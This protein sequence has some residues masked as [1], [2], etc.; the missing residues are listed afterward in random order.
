MKKQYLSIL[1]ILCLLLSMLAGCKKPNAES[2]ALADPQQVVSSSAE[3]PTDDPITDVLSETPLAVQDL[4]AEVAY[5]TGFV[6]RPPDEEFIRGQMDFSVELFRQIAQK[7]RCKNTLIAPF[8]VS[9]ALAMTANGAEGQTLEEMQK[10]LGG[11]AI[12][13][14]NAYYLNWRVGLQGGEKTKLHIADSIWIRDLQGFEAKDAFLAAN[15][16]YYDA[17]VFKAPFNQIGQKAINEWVKEKTDGMIPQLIEELRPETMMILINAL[18]FDAQWSDPYSEHQVRDGIFHSID[19]KEQK[20]Q[21]MGSTEYSY[22]EGE[23]AIGFTRNYLGGRYAFGALLPTETSLEE[24]VATLDG[25]TLLQILKNQQGTQ[26]RAQLPKFSS[27]FGVSMNEALEA[28]GMPSAFEGGFG[29]MS[30]EDLFIGNVLHK[31]VIEVHEDGT[32]AAA[33]TAVEMD[34]ST[35]P[36]AEP[37]VVTLDRPFLYFIFDRETNLP[38]F[39]GSLTSLQ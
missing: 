27:E 10:V 3:Q 26:V 15:A 36:M 4:T 14:L 35:A 30:N 9:M 31:T 17:Q 38:I 29:K 13:T 7:T 6:V 21:M 8:S 32:R 24:Y 16:K 2:G 22:L 25:E 34:K 18:S 1:I 39:L 12:D 20:A 33:A 28:M 23:G 11:H 19:G 5:D 37:K